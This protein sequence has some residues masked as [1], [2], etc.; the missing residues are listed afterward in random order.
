MGTSALYFGAMMTE[1]GRILALDLGSKRVGVAL[2]DA[3]QITAQPFDTL[4]VVSV[5]K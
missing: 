4:E 3:L 2:S 5:K 1:L